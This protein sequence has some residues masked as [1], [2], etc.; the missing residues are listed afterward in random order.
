M[1]DLSL[2]DATIAGAIGHIV[3]AENEMLDGNAPRP[4]GG[5][6]SLTGIG[7]EVDLYLRGMQVGRAAL[8]DAAKTA[9][10]GL[11]HL[12]EESTALD[13]DLAASLSAGFA[14]QGTKR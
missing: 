10:R 9:A 11:R 2:T 12:M 4:S 13:A 6:E 1:A 5:F 3:T 14:V 7:G 8:A